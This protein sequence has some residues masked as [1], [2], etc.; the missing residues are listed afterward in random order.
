MKLQVCAIK[1][2]AADTF[3]NV[4]VVP[5]TGIAIRNFQDALRNPDSGTMHTHPEDF[6]LYHIGEYDDS[7]AQI[8]AHEPNRIAVGKQLF[9]TQ[10]A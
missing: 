7:T 6:D 3:G 8:E 4:F 9:K 1:D 5:H 10:G 2:H